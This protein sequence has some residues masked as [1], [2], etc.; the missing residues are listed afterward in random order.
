MATRAPFSSQAHKPRIAVGAVPMPSKRLLVHPWFI[1]AAASAL[2]AAAVLLFP[3]SALATHD[4][5][6]IKEATR[7]VRA[8]AIGPE[9][10][11]FQMLYGVRRDLQDRLVRDGWRE[12]GFNA[13]G[14]QA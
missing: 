5:R 7:Y 13:P 8:N 9:R 3:F 10:F 12:W 6:I 11:E 4:D 1:A 2:V 14:T